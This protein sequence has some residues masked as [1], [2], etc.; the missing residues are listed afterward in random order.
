MRF[1]TAAIFSTLAAFAAAYTKPD[2]SQSPDGN[3]IYTP[4]LNEQVPEGE[5]FQI[6]WDPTVGDKV[7]LVLLRG[8]S[9]DVVPLETIVEDID[10]TGSYTWTPGTNLEVDTTHYGLLLVVEGTGQY[11]WSTQFGISKGKSS[12]KTESTTTAPST[13]AATSA[14][15]T[16]VTVI[17]DKTTTICPETQSQSA[18]ATPAVTPTDSASGAYTTVTPYS[19]IT[20]TICPESESKTAVSTAGVTSVPLPSAVSISRVPYASTLRSS[21]AVPSTTGKAAVSPS[22]TPFSGAGRNAASFGAVLA[23]IVAFMAL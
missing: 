3:P 5:P 13:T 2:Y 23:G 8:P 1:T 10:N 6:T 20:T 9:S 12:G 22:A 11:Q 17:D 4:S 7:S 21:V 15:A 18:T 19:E 16:I 14:P